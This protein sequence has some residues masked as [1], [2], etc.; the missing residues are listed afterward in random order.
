MPSAVKTGNK[1]G[2]LI[3]ISFTFTLIA[4]EIGRGQNRQPF[5]GERDEIDIQFTF[6]QNPKAE[7]NKANN[8]TN[9]TTKH[10]HVRNHNI[11]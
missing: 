3:E 2:T 7:P 5:Q 9:Y 6:S 11:H 10:N 8:Q 1:H 4:A